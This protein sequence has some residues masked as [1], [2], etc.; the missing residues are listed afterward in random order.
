MIEAVKVGSRLSERGFLDIGSL[1][2][3]YISSNISIILTCCIFIGLIIWALT[4][5]QRDELLIIS[6]LIAWSFIFIYHR[7]YDYFLYP[8]VTIFFIQSKIDYREQSNDSNIKYLNSLLTVGIIASLIFVTCLI[9]GE[10]II[11]VFTILK[12][13]SNFSQM[14]NIT[15]IFSFYISFLCLHLSA[16]QGYKKYIGKD[17][18]RIISA[19]AASISERGRR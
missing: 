15:E 13:K 9:I 10:S 11:N 1:T 3:K 7:K 5:N 4:T 18:I 8:M 16:Y 14:L 6:I 19:R 2:G 17:T 12:I